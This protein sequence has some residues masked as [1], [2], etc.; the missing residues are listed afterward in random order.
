MF[1]LTFVEL[2]EKTVKLFEKLNDN[3]IIHYI[4]YNSLYYGH[5][6]IISFHFYKHRTYK[7][8]YNALKRYFKFMKIDINVQQINFINLF[9]IN[10]LVK[11]ISISI[12]MYNSYRLHILLI[13]GPQT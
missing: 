8:K 9:L 7:I 5:L 2:N 13:Y 6:M 1:H 11:H 3:I 4:L 10:L 12:F